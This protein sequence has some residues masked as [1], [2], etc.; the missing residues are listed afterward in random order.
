MSI[1]PTRRSFLATAGVTAASIVAPRVAAQPQTTKTLPPGVSFPGTRESV[2]DMQADHPTLVS[3]R[4]AIAA[5]QKLPPT[6][7]L[8]WRF[9]ASMHGT[10]GE[11]GANAAWSWCMH[12]NWWF[13][14]WHRGYLYFFERIIR[15][16]S[17]DDGFR[18][19]YWPWEAAGHNV[20]PAP[21]RDPTYSGQKNW[22]F[23][24]TRKEANTGGPLQPETASGSFAVDWAAALATEQFTS[25][26]IE[27]AY[28][29]LR[30][31]K[32]AMPDKPRSA[33][34]HGVMES[35]AHD[36]VHDVVGG[37]AGNMG[38][39]RTAARDP[40]FWLHH[41]NVDR[42]WNRWRD[43]SG[44]LW[45]DLCRAKLWSHLLPN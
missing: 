23:D 35:R 34:R 40:I 9:Q 37:E 10:L 15:K 32:T 17:G 5:M 18:L 29:G 4:T 39:P 21:F 16:M 36:M 3:Y 8:S 7:P 22:L 6:D 42:L 24:E 45:P 2:A 19:P 30:T 28:G 38:D 11:D 14:P 1:S 43:I 33:G 12:G 25:S 20:L 13:L 31:Q 27:F 26:V 41:A 44:H